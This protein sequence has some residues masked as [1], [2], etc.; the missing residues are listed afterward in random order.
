MSISEPQATSPAPVSRLTFAYD[1]GKIRLVSEQHV[2]M[3][4]PPTQPIDSLQ[5]TAGFSVILRNDSGDPVYERTV[6]GL[7]RYDEEVFDNVPERSIR[8]EAN[9]HPK[10]A[11]VLLVPAIESARKLEF[12]GP[13][14]K[15]K[16]QL[17]LPGPLAS[18][19]LS[20]L[21]PP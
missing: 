20:P 19:T 1:G 14:L 12:F 7:M 11:F 2:N 4:I 17:E 5:K 15:P 8:R 10:G 21:P 16:A 6:E 13:P 3:I 18:F 9:P